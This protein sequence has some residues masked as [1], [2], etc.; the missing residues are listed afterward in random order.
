[1]PRKRVGKSDY[2][3][4]GRLRMLY[5]KGSVGETNRK[6]IKI[7]L[8][9]ETMLMMQHVV[10]VGKGLYGAPFIELATR[11]LFSIIIGG[12]EVDDIIRELKLVANNQDIVDNLH[13]ITNIM[14]A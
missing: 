5:P 1:M 8:T 11:F 10:P 13:R 2:V 4:L 6:R 14:R 9:P 12:E 7:T 3:N